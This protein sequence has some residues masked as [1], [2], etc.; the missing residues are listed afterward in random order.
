MFYNRGNKLNGMILYFPASKMAH[1]LK[2]TKHQ[3]HLK[4]N[5]KKKNL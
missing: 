4:N 2:K 3:I 1:K 5:N